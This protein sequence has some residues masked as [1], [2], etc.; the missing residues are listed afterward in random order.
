VERRRSFG[1]DSNRGRVA[2]HAIPPPDWRAGQVTDFPGNPRQRLKFVEQFAW[3]P[4]E[5]QERRSMLMHHAVIVTEEG[6]RGVAS[7]E[8][9]VDIIEHHFGLL[10][11]EFNVIC[12][13]PEPFIILFSDR[14][15]RDLVFARDRVIDGPVQLR[16]HQWDV[17][18]FGERSIVPFHVKLSLKGLPH[19]AWFREIAEKVVV[20]DAVIH[21]VEQ[22]T[23]RRSDMR[24]YVC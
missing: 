10:R 19:H 11:Y 6:P 1:N 2:P 12:T 22:G 8:D 7:K 20:S 16:F 9:V 5:I 3:A 13:N 18:H 23:R 14:A 15:A 17:D 24:F 4:D 21:H